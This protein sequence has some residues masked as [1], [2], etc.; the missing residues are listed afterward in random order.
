MQDPEKCESLQ[1]IRNTIDFLDRHII[2]LIGERAKYV[3]A[4][5]KFKKDHDAV[6]APERFQ[7]MLAKRREWAE[8][9]ELDPDAIENMY[10]HLV[11][12]FIAKELAYWNGNKA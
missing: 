12:H 7:S 11:N 5:A 6:R 2:H 8:Q 1:E 9:E 4:A 3:K 10:F